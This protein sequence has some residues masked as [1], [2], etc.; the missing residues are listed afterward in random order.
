MTTMFAPR[1]AASIVA[2][3]VKPELGERFRRD[4]GIVAPPFRRLE[5]APQRRQD[6]PR[7][8]AAQIVG[9]GA[10]LE[11]EAEDRDHRTVGK[12][13]H[14]GRGR[15]DG[16]GRLLGHPLVD[17]AR[18]QRDLGLQP[19]RLEAFRQ[20][21]GILLETRSADRT[22]NREIGPRIA[23]LAG[24]DH[25]HGADAE[26][27]AHPRHLVGEGELHVALRIVDEL[28]HLRGFEIVHAQ[29]RRR[30]ELEELR[31][32]HAGLQ[33]SAADDLRKPAQLLERHALQRPLG[34]ERDVVGEP[35]LVENRQDD[36]AR[37]AEHHR[38]TQDHQRPGLHGAGHFAGGM[39]DHVEPRAAVRAER[40]SDRD[41]EDVGSEI[42]RNG[43]VDLEPIVFEDAPEQIREARL[44]EMRLALAQARDDVLADFDSVHAESDIRHRRRERQPDIAEPDDADVA[45]GISVRN[46][47][48]SGT[49]MGERVWRLW[50]VATAK[51]LC[52]WARSYRCPGEP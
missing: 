50:G 4:D 2:Q 48:E 15:L 29:R 14:R 1:T 39:L 22:G 37:G 16:G 51:R 21:V 28:D 44:V 12:A 5:A 7:H 46:S 32:T 45:V 20:N 23:E 26:G 52:V 34:A 19:E 27:I 33:I 38:R 13:G 9:G 36:L 43:A 17:P 31:G 3:G 8:R 35:A 30:D 25:V 42:R 40:G 11:R 49:V 41:D 47:H 6:R 10:S 24:R 18:A